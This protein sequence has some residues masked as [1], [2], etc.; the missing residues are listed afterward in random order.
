MLHVLTFWV[1][2]IN[3]FIVLFNNA[4]AY[5][6]K[7]ISLFLVFIIHQTKLFYFIL[8]GLCYEGIVE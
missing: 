7:I 8:K 5:K 3:K 4:G 2:C 6:L 1:Q